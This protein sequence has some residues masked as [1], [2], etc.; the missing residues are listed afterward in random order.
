MEKAAI[1]KRDAILKSTLELIA[2]HGFHGAPAAMI[3]HRANVGVGTIYR[4]FENKDLLIDAL[5][6][7]IER[8]ITECLMDEYRGDLPVRDRFVCIGKRLLKYFTE[9]PVEFRFLEQ[10]INS[11][12]GVALRRN[13]LF[14]ESGGNGDLLRDLFLEGKAG[15]VL[16]DL[17]LIILYSLACG[18][19]LMVS[20]DHI[21]GFFSLDEDLVDITVDACWQA[22]RR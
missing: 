2:E 11:P 7:D 16:K 8:K 3:A 19:L 9:N 14:G 18:P 13:K 21:M 6:K 4:Y 17:P 22:I 5:F 15:G 20:R 12:Y 10:F 1:R